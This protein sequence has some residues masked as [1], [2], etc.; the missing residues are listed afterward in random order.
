MNDLARVG[1]AMMTVKEVAEAL[2]LSPQTIRKWAKILYP[3]IVINGKRTMLNELQVTRI[4]QRILNANG[5]LGAITIIEGQFLPE[6]AQERKNRLW[7]VV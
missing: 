4:K 3:K 7:R 2:D 1:E 6:L 5:H